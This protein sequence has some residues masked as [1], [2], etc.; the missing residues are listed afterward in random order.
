MAAIHDP[1]FTPSLDLKQD[2]KAIKDFTKSTV[3]GPESIRNKS[4]TI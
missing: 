2:A 3:A 4:Y 1:A